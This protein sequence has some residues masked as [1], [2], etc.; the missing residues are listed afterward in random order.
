MAMASGMGAVTTVMWTVLHAGDHLLAD[1]ALY[2]CT[3]SFFTRGL[4]RYG[5]EVTL[6]DFEDL[7]AVRAAI[8]PNT[9]AFYFE[10]PRTRTSSSLT[11]PQSPRSRMRI[12]PTQRLLLTTRLQHLTSS[13]PSISV[14]M[15]LSTAQPSIL[16]V[17]AMLLRAWRQAQRN[18]SMSATCSA[19]RI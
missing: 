17:T 8:R 12:A 16:T 9:K 3:F 15:L 1:D 13:V 10:T 5:V 6:V 7:D 18:S 19:L 11:L 4:T 14:R 2:G